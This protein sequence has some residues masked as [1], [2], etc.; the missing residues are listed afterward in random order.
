MRY[1]YF[2][3]LF[4]FFV[5]F[6]LAGLWLMQNNSPLDILWLGYE[7]HTS[8]AFVA[9]LTFAFS[10]L[11]VFASYIFLWVIGLPTRT[12]NK[13]NTKRMQGGLDL[14]TKGFIAYSAGDSAVAQRYTMKA[15]KKLGEQN[16]L[17]TILSAEIARQAGDSIAMKQHYTALLNHKETEYLGL[18]GLIYQA[19]KEKDY[20]TLISLGEK[21]RK[22]KPKDMWLNAVLLGGYKQQKRW[23]DAE[24]E[25]D[26]LVKALKK[27]PALIETLPHDVHEEDFS[28]Q[29][30]LLLYQRAREANAKHEFK[31][32]GELILQ[33]LKYLPDFTPA[34]LLAAQILPQSG[35]VRKLRKLIEESWYVLPHPDLAKA[36]ALVL[37]NE[38]GEKRLKEAERLLNIKPDSIESHKAVAVAAISAGDLSKA[39][40]HVKAALQLQE[41]PSLCQLMAHLA[42]LENDYEQV[43][44]WKNRATLATP[45]PLWVCASCSHQTH[46][47]DISCSSCST[48]D[49]Y[50]WQLPRG[51][52]PLPEPDALVL[53]DVVGKKSSNQKGLRAWKNPYAGSGGE[54]A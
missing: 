43:E 35:G 37:S 32:A 26:H 14:L 28:R 6:G 8:V 18:K 42:K 19:Q 44:A 7:I 54:S 27:Q 21:A 24:D 10:I 4:L 17:S 41:T 33:S 25:L 12:V 49:S 46:H 38:S 11:L 23:H 9:I 30:G 2:L 48:W 51:A 16:L 13:W 15:S 52:A 31:L 45:E 34:Y 22:L 53:M 5:L 29:K 1:F 3:G 47:W 50:E 20:G 39:R 40:N 36:Q